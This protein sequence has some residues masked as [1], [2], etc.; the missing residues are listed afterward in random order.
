[1]AEQDTVVQIEVD[2]V[3]AAVSVT[4]KGAA[5]GFKL[6]LEDLADGPTS[7]LVVAH[8]VLVESRLELTLEAEDDEGQTPMF[9]GAIPRIESVA[10]CGRI[11]AGATT[12]A[13]RLSF[14]RKSV[15]L[16]SLMALAGKTA[17]LRARR[18]GVAGGT[19]TQADGRPEAGEDE[20]VD[21]ETGEPLGAARVGEGA[22]VA[23]AGGAA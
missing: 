22:A 19:R 8:Q 7:G 13:A 17:L 5:I 12:L 6:N 1:M 11:S 14:D 9:E 10:D 16:D 2:A 15:D 4:E 20:D 21:P 3:L 23:H 18:V